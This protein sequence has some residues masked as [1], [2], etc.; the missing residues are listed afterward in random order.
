[1]ETLRNQSTSRRFG[2]EEIA[3]LKMKANRLCNE[4][5]EK[6]II[7]YNK[8]LLF[9]SYRGKEYVIVRWVVMYYLFEVHKLKHGE[10]ASI[11]NKDR[12]TVIHAIRSINDLFFIKDSFTIFVYATLRDIYQEMQTKQNTDFPDICLTKSK[13]YTNHLQHEPF[14]PKR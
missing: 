2:D 10:I 4:L 5:G 11:F 12:V 14:R 9:S 1:M 3:F 7:N 8:E 13:D 6:T